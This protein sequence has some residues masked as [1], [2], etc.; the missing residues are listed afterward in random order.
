MASFKTHCDDCSIHLGLPYEDVHKWLDFYASSFPPPLFSEYH[1]S[2]R[3]NN[4]GVKLCQEYFGV[5]AGYAAMI[6]IV[7]DLNRWYMR[8]FDSYDLDDLI[9]LYKK[10]NVKILNDPEGILDCI[11]PP[12]FL[13]NYHNE[14]NMG[15]SAIMDVYNI[16]KERKV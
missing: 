6:H 16:D 15:Y 9:V 1:R 3:H 2:F 13:Y 5:Q 7:R 10:L 8:P 4:R 11:I 12:S 14:T